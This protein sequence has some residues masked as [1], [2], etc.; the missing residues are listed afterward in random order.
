MVCVTINGILT[1][2]VGIPGALMNL[3]HGVESHGFISK[4]IFELSLEF[5][6]VVKRLVERGSSFRKKL[7]FLSL[8]T[9]SD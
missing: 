7:I 5:K 4:V 6:R 2:F 9:R 1:E 3:S 8:G